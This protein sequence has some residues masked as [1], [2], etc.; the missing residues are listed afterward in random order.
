MRK[1]VFL[2]RDGVLNQDPPHYA[3]RIDQL[4]MIPRVDDAIR[5]LHDSGYLLVVITNQSGVARGY[6][7]EEQVGVFNEALRKEIGK[8]GGDIDA[9]YYCP[10]HPEAPLE[11]YRVE[12]NCRKPKP[13]M[14]LEAAQKFT[15]DLSQSFLVGDKATDI[16]AG[17]NAGCRTILV[18]SGQGT[19][20]VSKITP[21]DCLVA[22]D[23]YD[24]A[25]RFILGGEGA[26]R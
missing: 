25:T 14:I 3:H 2:D 11:R 5:L 7:P 1:A 9:I 16:Q 22:S 20:E 12:C 18:L 17:K 6:Y 23:L 21:G 15:V 13:G 10:H 24:A 19:D 4:V 8:K 26:D